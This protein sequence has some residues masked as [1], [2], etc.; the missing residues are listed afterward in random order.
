[1]VGVWPPGRLTPNARTLFPGN[2]MTSLYF[3]STCGESAT[4]SPGLEPSAFAT[5]SLKWGQTASNPNIGETSW[6]GYRR[7]SRRFTLIVAAPA[8]RGERRGDQEA[9]R[10]RHVV[11]CWKDGNE[12]VMVPLATDR[13]ASQ[14][15]LTDIIRHRKR[16]EAGLVNTLKQ[17]I[18]LSIEEHT[19]DYLAA[20]RSL[21]RPEPGTST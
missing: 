1:M 4:S 3:V 9:A 2:R 20:L 5:P 11:R 19:G 14:A 12:K 10:I 7:S 15:R 21:I 16:G 6:R 18:D 8:S 13:Q 17:N